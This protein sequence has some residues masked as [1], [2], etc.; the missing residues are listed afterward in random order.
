MNKECR[1]GNGA[2]TGAADPESVSSFTRNFTPIPRAV[3]LDAPPAE[4]LSCASCEACCCRLEVM[5]M[6]GDDVPPALTAQ[7]RWGGWVMR[8]L[9]DGWCAALDRDTLRCTIYARRP[10]ICREF[11]V[12]DYEC[13]EERAQLGAR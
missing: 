3:A 4:E 5:L 7:D 9:G 13:L 6:G 10:F 8:R 1:S 11:E 12:G 2:R